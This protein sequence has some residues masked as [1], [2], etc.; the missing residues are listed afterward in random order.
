MSKCVCVEGV[1]M[2]S[3]LLMNTFLAKPHVLLQEEA[4]LEHL[5]LDR[6]QPCRSDF[7]YD[8]QKF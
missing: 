8:E 2:G 4:T 6:V 3:G 1:G 5:S 7:T